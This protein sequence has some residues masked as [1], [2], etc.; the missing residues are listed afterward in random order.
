MDEEYVNS[1]FAYL[2]VNITTKA[3][4]ALVEFQGGLSA[5]SG[6]VEAALQKG[7]EGVE[8]GFIQPSLQQV[9]VCVY[10][11]SLLP[12]LQQIFGSQLA[13][14][15]PFLPQGCSQDPNRIWDEEVQE[16]ECPDVK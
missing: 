9:R 13:I 8:G 6:E 7:G 2:G 3:L 1:L 12:P 4:S 5:Q 15:D 10:Y 16:K 11:I 14:C